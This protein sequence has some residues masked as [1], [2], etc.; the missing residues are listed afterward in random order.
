[1]L[2]HAI[3]GAFS[4][5]PAGGAFAQPLP[6]LPGIPTDGGL[7]NV[8][9]GWLTNDAFSSRQDILDLPGHVVE[10]DVFVPGK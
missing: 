3:G 4:T 1:M 9:P 7:F 2:A 6:G 5:P 10:V 8:V